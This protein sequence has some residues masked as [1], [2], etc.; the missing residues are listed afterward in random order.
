MTDLSDIDDL[1]ARLERLGDALDLD[2]AH[3]TDE[4]L[5]RIGAR[6]SARLPR[7]WLVAAV[8][9]LVVGGVVAHPDSRHAVA[10]WFGL[11]GLVIDVDP[12]LSVPE[13]PT[14]VD[15]PGPGESRVVVVGD[16]EILVSAVHGALTDGLISKTVSS[17][18]QVEEVDVDGHRGL[19]ISGAPHQVLYE[20]DGGVVVERVAANALV[21][22]RDDVLY[23]VEGFE[24]LADALGFVEGT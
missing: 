12:D 20:A 24:L 2:D 3:V 11:D 13:T 7:R 10:R 15:A 8:I 22:Q 18:D 6:R 17:S 21:W 5:D 23:R 16:R 4:I 1:V 14:L 9:V 19:W